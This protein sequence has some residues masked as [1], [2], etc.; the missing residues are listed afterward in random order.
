MQERPISLGPRLLLAMEKI[1][2]KLL[3]IA[4]A[5]LTALAA[6]GGPSEPS[7]VELVEYLGSNPEARKGAS[8]RHIIRFDIDVLR[9]ASDQV[10]VFETPDRRRFELETIEHLER[11]DRNF[12]WRG[13]LWDGMTE[14][15]GVITVNEG[16]VSGRLWMGDASFEFTPTPHGTELI[17]LDPTGFGPEE[18]GHH[19]LDIPHSGDGRTTISNAPVT[20]DVL[21]VYTQN[22]ANAQGGAAA[23]ETLI[24]SA[25]D[26]TN[27]ALGDSGVS[28][29][30]N[31]ARAE[32]VNYN[33]TGVALNDQLNW[34][35]LD[36][37]V[38]NLRNTYHA[39]MVVLMTNNGAGYCGSGYVMQNVGPAFANWAFS[40]T[41]STCAVG[42]LTF[43]HE[44]GHNLGLEHDPA[45][46]AAPADASFPYAFGYQLAGEFRTIMAYAC[47]GST[48]NREGYFSNPNVSF[49]GFPTGVVDQQD[50]ARALDDTM[51][52]TAGYR[53]PPS[54]PW[55]L[56][57]EDYCA[58]CGPCA[59]GEGDCEA[60]QCDSGLVCVQDVGANY[61]WASTVDVCEAPAATPVTIEAESGTVFG[62][63]S[64]YND[65]SASGG[66][67]V[68]YLGTVGAG[69]E[70]MGVP[71]S[72]SFTVRYAST[73]TGQLSFFVNGADTGDISFNSTGGWVGNYQDVTV[74]ATIPSGATFE[75]EHVS[76]DSAMNVD[77]VTFD[78]VP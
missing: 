4:I 25:I 46:G 20:V 18:P 19:W 7:S 35:R 48:C 74:Q 64:V 52:H 9:R 60:G 58:D 53:V 16:H 70:L 22:G 36:S 31:L 47:S 8:E 45:N 42:N 50:N 14:G 26:V 41:A 27:A 11:P 77:N 78:G 59:A 33:E 55:N 15:Y 49:N 6:C 69:F 34:L 3:R 28:H 61:G 37:T 21:V 40:V 2:M 68:A 54:C 72:S 56:G 39:D 12:M 24:Q 57:D 32:Q 73:L 63:S 13:H 38:A 5:L 17:E 67:G 75:I 43:A 10:V 30:L 23:M 66:Q 65:G 62:G 51:P 44:L 1:S 71:A 29:S 76:G